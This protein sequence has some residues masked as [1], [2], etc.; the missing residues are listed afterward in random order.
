MFGLIMV[1]SSWRE[2]ENMDTKVVYTLA[3]SVH[4]IIPVHEFRRVIVK[5]V[6]L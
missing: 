5:Y 6:P 2:C 4:A 3:T 1:I